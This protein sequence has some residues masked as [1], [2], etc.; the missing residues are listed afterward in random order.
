MGVGFLILGL[1]VTGCFMVE[2]YSRTLSSHANG[3]AYKVSIETGKVIWRKSTIQVI[4]KK[5]IRLMI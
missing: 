3:Y 1:A 4:K 2:I 5:G